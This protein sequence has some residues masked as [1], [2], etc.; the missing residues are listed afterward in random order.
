MVYFDRFSLPSAV[1][2]EM[3]RRAKHGTFSGTDTPENR[4]AMKHCTAV[5]LPTGTIIIFTADVG[6][7]SSGWW[8]NPDY[9][10]C[11]HLSLSYRDPISGSYVSHDHKQ[12][13]IWLDA[14]FTPDDQRKLWVE[15]PKTPQGKESDVIHYRLFCDEHWKPIIP[16]EEVYSKEFTEVGWKSYSEIMG[17]KDE[18][19]ET[20]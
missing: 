18:L 13:K 3:Y 4:K 10:R 19:P 6:Y 15:T 5:H 20:K 7:H 2:R 16:R 9:E 17:Q 14:F 12:S 11:W 1:A 8:K